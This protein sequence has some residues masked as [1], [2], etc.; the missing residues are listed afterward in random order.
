MA[1][2]A[3]FLFSLALSIPAIALALELTAL[4]WRRSV[5]YAL[6]FDRDRAEDASGVQPDDNISTRRAFPQGDWLG[7]A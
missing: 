6:L 1:R 3:A 5:I 7:C 2:N 4:G